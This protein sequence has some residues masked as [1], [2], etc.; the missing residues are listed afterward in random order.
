MFEP[1]LLNHIAKWSN[2]K[3]R[4]GVSGQDCFSFAMSWAAPHLLVWQ[5]SSYRDVRRL[6]RQEGYASLEDYVDAS[7]RRVEHPQDGDVVIVDGSDGFP[8]FGLW[9]DEKAWVPSPENGKIA[10]SKIEPKRAWRWR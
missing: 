3:I 8:A 2:T 9:F 10:G 4:G 7:L 5:Y 1:T 6:L